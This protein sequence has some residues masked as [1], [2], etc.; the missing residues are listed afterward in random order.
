MLSSPFFLY[1]SLVLPVAFAAT[2]KTTPLAISAIQAHF[3]QALLVPEVFPTFSPDATLD[4]AFAASPISPGQPLAQADVGTKPAVTISALDDKSLTGSFTIAM[5][6]ADVV[7]ADESGGVNRHWLENGVTV[8]DGALSNA[9]ATVIT[10][11][12]GPGPASGSGPHRYV[13]LLYQQPTTFTAPADLS[14]LVDGVQK[15]DLNAYVKNSGLG[16]L[17][18]ANYFTVEV[19]TDSTSLPATS[20]VVTSTLAT[21]S[22]SA[23]AST[24]SG[25]SSAPAPS[26]S[27][28]PNGASKLNL[29]FAPVLVALAMIALLQ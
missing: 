8:A 26:G 2:T 3:K 15:F 23:G 24:A 17:V 12:A 10:A 6:D 18:A 7:G 11:Y 4:I 25:A 5:V 1:L 16:N 28:R 19:G 27:T 20:S 13:V 21:R 9:S 29:G 14:K 22:A